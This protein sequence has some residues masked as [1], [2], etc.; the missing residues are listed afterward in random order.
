[1]LVSSDDAAR[2]TRELAC[3]DGVL[4]GLSSG[5]VL[6]AAVEYAARPINR[7]KLVVIMLCDGLGRYMAARERSSGGIRR[8]QPSLAE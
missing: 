5:A 8:Q 2:M 3:R 1:M 6:H 4:A 7:N